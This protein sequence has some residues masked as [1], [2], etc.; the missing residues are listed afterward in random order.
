MICQPLHWIDNVDADVIWG[1]GGVGD[2]EGTIH[3]V[4]QSSQHFVLKLVIYADSTNARFS[5]VRKIDS[6]AADRK[7]IIDPNRR[8]MI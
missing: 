6:E 8:Q 1:F 4:A 3:V 5:Y 7:T 2:V